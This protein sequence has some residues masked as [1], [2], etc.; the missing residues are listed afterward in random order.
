MRQ[1]NAISDKGS[2]KSNFELPIAYRD[3]SP[4]RMKQMDIRKPE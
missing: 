3:L 1:G 4:E 2:D